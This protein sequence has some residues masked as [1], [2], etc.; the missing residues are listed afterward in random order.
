MVNPW[1]DVIVFLIA[2][3][4]FP[5]VNF[6]ISALL[7]RNFPYREKMAPYESGEEP[8]GDARVHFRIQ[9]FFFALIFLVFDVEVVF[10]Y[11]WA[12]VLRDIGLFGYIVMLLFVLTLVEGLVYA[13]KKGVLRW[14]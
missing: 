8:F 7:R 10:L 12:L 11:P 13:Y 9:Y 4:T 6:G 5:F 1:I 2:G 14:I 3:L